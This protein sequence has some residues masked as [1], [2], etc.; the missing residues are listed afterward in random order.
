MGIEKMVQDF[1]E[2]ASGDSQKLREFLVL[3][4]SHMSFCDIS[5]RGPRSITQLIDEFESALEVRS[6]QKLVDLNLQ[7]S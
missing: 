2:R 3:E 4:A 7:L 5:W 1:A 6:I